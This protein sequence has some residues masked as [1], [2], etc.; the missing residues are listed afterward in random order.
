MKLLSALLLLCLATLSSAGVIVESRVLALAEM[1]KLGVE[2]EVSSLPGP[3]EAPRHAI[4]V[5]VMTAD[6]LDRF[7]WISFSILA[8][9]LDADFAA[10]GNAGK[11]DSATW[12]KPVR[13]EASNK[14]SL[15][16]RV[17]DA[18]VPFGYVKL[19]LSRS[20]KDG[21]YDLGDYYLPLTQ[22]IATNPAPAA[23]GLK[24][25]T[26]ELSAGLPPPPKPEAIFK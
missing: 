16:F 13:S 15:S 4:T 6:P 12:A 25:S 3:R 26:A 20:P 7:L 18:E 19:N 2:I 10:V 23:A 5:R 1:Q 17:S 24:E 11:R 9:A 22:L 21:T 14:P 8:R